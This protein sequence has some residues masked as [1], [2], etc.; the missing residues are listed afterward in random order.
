MSG[1]LRNHL[2]SKPFHLFAIL[3]DGLAHR[4]EQNHL[5]AGVDDVAES[6][7]QFAGGTGYRNRLYARHVAVDA[8]QSGEHPFAGA[9]GSSSTIK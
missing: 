4:V 7:H 8:V 6:A 1:E 3:G 9:A 5:G 2:C